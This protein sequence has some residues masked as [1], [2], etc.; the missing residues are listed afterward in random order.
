LENDQKPKTTRFSAT[1]VVIIILVSLIAG[2]LIGYSVSSLTF[3]GSMRDLQ[4]QVSALQG[5]VS[6]LQ[7][8]QSV[9][10]QSSTQ[11][12]GG[13]SSLAQLYA[14]VKDS[15]V[16]IRGFTVQH[17]I[18][19]RTYYTEVQGSGFIYNVAAKMVAVTN[20]HVVQGAVNITVTFIN[21]DAYAAT[22]LG[23]DPY[24]DLAVLST[25]APQSEYKPLGIVDSSTLSVGD[26]VVA[27][28]SPY[29]LAGSM[30]TGIVSALGRTITE[31]MSGG[32][33][34][35]DV[36]QTSTPINPGNSGGPLLNYQ[37]QVVGITTAIVSSSQGVGFAIPSSTVLREIGSLVTTG[38]YDKHPTIGATGTDMTYEIAKAMGVN[39][40]YGW[41]IA[42][43]TSGGPA[44]EANLRG[45]TQQVTVV[46]QSVTIGGDIIIA[47]NGT[48][49][50]GIDDLSTFLEEHTLPGQTIEV[51]I[52]RNGQSM[53][54]SLKL[55]SRSA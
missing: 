32:Y 50:T 52:I 1:F 14:Q 54:L 38:S 16:V 48:R 44:A 13:N 55:G 46:G 22:A 25:D 8:A 51:T 42:Q 24:A 18:F 5:Q 36:I 6:S 35:A 20:Y 43:V 17:D 21:G 4:N 29:G 37:G 27:V 53:T 34:I 3:S 11:I 26:S 40:T 47:I 2:G 49:I 19:G 15:V 23:S 30:T 39:V 10:G 7:S 28:G 45:G 9:V 31:D 41:L 12:V 33:P